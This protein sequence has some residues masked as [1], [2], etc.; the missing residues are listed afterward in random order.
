MTIVLTERTPPPPATLLPQSFFDPTPTQR[1]LFLSLPTLGLN[2]FGSRDPLL[3][4]FNIYH[5]VFIH[6]DFNSV[7]IHILLL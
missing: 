6:L 2:S 1:L 5:Y 4:F 7:P 3:Q